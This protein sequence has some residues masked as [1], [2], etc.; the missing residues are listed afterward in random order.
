MAALLPARPRSLSTCSTTA[1]PSRCCC[2][3]TACRATPRPSPLPSRSC[4][5]TSSG[6]PSGRLRQPGHLRCQI[7]LLRRGRRSRAGRPTPIPD[8]GSGGRCS[9]SCSASSRPASTSS[10]ASEAARNDGARRIQAL[11]VFHMCL[12]LT[13]F[14]GPLPPRRPRKA[15]IPRRP[16]GRADHPPQR[17]SPPASARTGP[18]QTR[19][20][21]RSGARSPVDH[22]RGAHPVGLLLTWGARGG[23]PAARSA[24]PSPASPAS[25]SWPRPLHPHVAPDAALSLRASG[26]VEKFTQGGPD[27]AGSVRQAFDF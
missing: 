10:T 9:S 23:T 8:A 21:M 17:A 3:G 20:S 24:R 7:R 2:T 22:R 5:T 16:A 14:R 13:G 11:E 12:L 6:P 27:V 15:Q 4:S 1:L 25:C 18:R 26:R 19:S